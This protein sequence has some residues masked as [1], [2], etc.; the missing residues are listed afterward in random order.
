MLPPEK[1]IA[2]Y[3]AICQVCDLE[4][5]KVYGDIGLGFIHVHHVIP[6]MKLKKN[7]SLIRLL[8]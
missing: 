3:G 6:L 7:I 4:F 5:S 8:I 1:C 2:H